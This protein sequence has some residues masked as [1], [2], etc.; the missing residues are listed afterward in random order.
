MWIAIRQAH[1]RLGTVKKFAI[2]PL[3]K[4]KCG[5]EI[6][7]QLQT[8]YKLFSLS[9]SDFHAKPNTNVSFFDSGLPGT[10]PK[11]NPEALYLALKTAVALNSNIQLQSSFDRKHYFYPDQPLGYQITQ[12]YHPIAKGGFVELNRLDG[13]NKDK[14]INLEQIQIEQDTGRTNYDKHDKSINVDLNRANTP[15]I[16]LVTKPDFETLDEVRAFVKKYQTLV[17]HLGICSGELETGAIRVDVNVSIN[18]QPRVEI[19][20]LGSNG[21]IQDAIKFEYT[22][23]VNEVKQNRPIIQ[24]TRGWN[25][26]ETVSKRRKENAVDYRYVPDSELPL[27]HLHESIADDIRNSLPALPDKIIKSLVEP[28]YKLELKYARFLI[29]NQEILSYYY[30]LFDV[31]GAAA[32]KWL[33]NELMAA[34]SKMNVK[35]DLSLIPPSKLSELI[36]KVNNN[37]ISLTSARLIMYEIVQNPANSQKSIDEL[38]EELDLA[39]PQ[40][41][42]EDL[43]EAIEEVC[44]D[45]MANNGDVVTKILNGNKKSIKYLVGLAMR[46]T[47]GKVS[48]KEFERKFQQLIESD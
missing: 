5:L 21:E 42:Q 48:A 43:N 36:A 28:P 17:K 13:I 10:Q 25:G 46:E 22:R 12:H 3:F 33:I 34:F 39:K 1:T 14:V 16:E 7:T 19:K 24:E 8:K 2:D 4:L 41:S 9:P 29:E 47:Q 26:N 44:R 15:L 18:D 38:V 20:N 35:L 45:I 11:L 31:V 32:N 37:E 40:V 6:H 30:K 27:I 23:Q